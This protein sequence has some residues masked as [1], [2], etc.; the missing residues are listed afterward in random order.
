MNILL[1]SVDF[2]PNVGGVAAHVY[3][4][5]RELAQQDH[6][7]S[8]LTVQ[9]PGA[10]LPEETLEGMTVRRITAG[11]RLLMRHTL[12]KAVA[13][14][15]AD[16]SPHV[17][18]V[19]GIKPLTATRGLSVP[20]IFTNHTS[21]FLKRVERGGAAV[22]RVGAMMAHLARVI[23]P[24]RELQEATVAVGYPSEHSLY[25]PNGVDVTRFHP[26]L[27]PGTLRSRWGVPDGGAVVM[28]ARRMVPKNGMTYLARAAA[29][30]L[31]EKTRLVLVGEGE[32][33]NEVRRYLD[34]GGVR[35]RTMLAGRVANPDMTAYYAASDVVVLPSLKE[36]TSITGLEAMACGRPLVGSNVGGIPELIVDGET[37]VLVPPADPDALAEGIG[38][39]L[40]NR[41]LRRRMGELARSRVVREFS[42]EVIAG[43]TVDVYCSVFAPKSSA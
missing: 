7:V 12:K 16:F 34:E 35:D 24:S 19:H 29:G 26:G 41:E 25:I 2:P 8:V 33:L 10:E 36:A 17:V 4:L 40:K 42:W 27:D 32:E 38:R 20:V 31:D 6:Q 39:V 5:G 18:H 1:V 11:P 13:A 22:R 21:G 15:V 3:E 14:A 30:F 43:R 37:G 9:V 28:A 23:S